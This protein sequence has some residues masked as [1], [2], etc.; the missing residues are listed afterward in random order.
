MAPDQNATAARQ[1]DLRLAVETLLDREGSS[2]TELSVGAICA[3]VGISRPTFYAYFDDKLDLV[4]A[5][6]AE[7]IGELVGVSGQWLAAPKRSRE[8]LEEAMTGLFEAYAPHRKV[9][10]AAAEVASYDPVLQ[11]RF[12]A[13]VEAASARVA[14]HI[15]D[16]QHEGL[17]RTDI[18][19][20]A[21]ARWLGWMTERGMRRAFAGRAMASRS[22]I[23]A[24][25]DIHWFTLYAGVG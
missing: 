8:E 4:R 22:D 7:T 5:L 18:D 23:S 16:G 24:M 13:A 21:T 14:E 20:G 11:D 6:A 15:A 25:T 3:E 9:M 10:A 17:I 2:F 12:N 1:A 19:A